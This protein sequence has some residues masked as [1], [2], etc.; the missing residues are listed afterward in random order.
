[1]YR[2]FTLFAILTFVSVIGCQGTGVG[3]PC[4]PEDV[5]AGGF[6]I[7]ET[8][9]ETSSVQCKTRVCMVRELQGDTNNI[10]SAVNTDPECVQQNEVDENVYCTCRCR[11]PAGSGVPTC[12]C[13]SGFEC[14]DILET[15]G[16]GLRGGYCT[17]VEP[18]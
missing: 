10:C 12:S 13:P 16:E 5:Q 18:S 15:G 7:S 4:L 9:L 1:M 3:D 6:E 14:T 17:R 8:Y 11:A 2:N